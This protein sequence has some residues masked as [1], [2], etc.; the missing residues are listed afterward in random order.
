[1]A[2]VT[3]HRR[4]LLSRTRRIEGQVA[5]LARSLESDIDC[6]AVLTQIAAV[7]GAV[8]GLMMKVLEDHLREHVVAEP[9]RRGRAREMAAVTAL[10]RTFVK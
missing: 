2:H 3:Q 5:A 7:R 9:R 6:G 4:K 8:Q 10:M 1:M